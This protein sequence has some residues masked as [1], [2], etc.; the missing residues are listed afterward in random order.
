[1]KRVVRLCVN[2]DQ[3]EVAVEP[4]TV[5]LDD[6]RDSLGLNGTRR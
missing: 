3:V 4:S 2:E 5:L 1:M 6:L